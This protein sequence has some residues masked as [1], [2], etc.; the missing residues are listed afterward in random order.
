MKDDPE[1]LYAQLPRVQPW[2]DDDWGFDYG[3]RI[4]A[5]PVLSLRDLDR[6]VAE[7]DWVLGRGARVIAL[8]P[9]PAYGR[10][11]ADPHFDP[12]WA[13]VDEA[14]VLVAFH[15]GESGYNEMLAPYWGEEAEPVVAP[16]VGV[17]VD[18]LL[19]RSADHGHVRRARAAQPV[20]TVSQRP[21][22]QRRERLACGS[23][24]C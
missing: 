10:S 14:G 19:R 24:T 11:P 9:G 21:L 23:R 7:L 15:V 17:P 20:R 16:P 5:P 12:F 3:G 18:V 2:L 1:Q 22:P 13:R 4:Y 6:A 8:R